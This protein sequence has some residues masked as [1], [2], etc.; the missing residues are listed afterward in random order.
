MRYYLIT[1]LSGEVAWE[2][3]ESDIANVTFLFAGLYARNILQFEGGIVSKEDLRSVLYGTLP[4]I[5][6]FLSQLALPLEFAI[7]EL[8]L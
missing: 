2:Q 3:D 5:N 8:Y 6:K 1:S 7:D 4:C